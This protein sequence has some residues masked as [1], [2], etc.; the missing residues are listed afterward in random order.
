MPIVD[1]M[2]DT[3]VDLAEDTMVDTTEARGMLM[4]MPTMDSDTLMP[5]AMAMLPPTTALVTTL[6]RGLLMLNLDT[7][8]DITED[9]VVM[10][11]VDTEDTTTVELLHDACS[12]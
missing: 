8:E 9:T 2:V 5:T 12:L 1:T 3:T 6:A 4:L 11:M 7:S 10:D